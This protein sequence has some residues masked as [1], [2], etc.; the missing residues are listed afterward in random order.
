[1][2]CCTLSS[3]DKGATTLPRPLPI[4]KFQYGLLLLALRRS[5]DDLLLGVCQES[6]LQPFSVLLSADTDHFTSILPPA[7]LAA[8]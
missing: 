3:T 4:I 7:L 5:V 8:S 2:A 6:L 1:M